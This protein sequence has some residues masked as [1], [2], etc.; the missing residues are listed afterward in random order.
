[1]VHPSG[2]SARPQTPQG[3]NRTGARRNPAVAVA[4]FIISAVLRGRPVSY[5]LRLYL[6]DPM[7]ALAAVLAEANA[8]FDVGPAN[9]RCSVGSAS[10]SPHGPFRD[11]DRASMLY[12]LVK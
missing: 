3:A 10:R 9:D 4:P 2:I 1:M 12:T 11:H 6:A 7:V 8:S 5:G